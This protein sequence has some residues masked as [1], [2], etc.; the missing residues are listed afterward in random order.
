VD[1]KIDLAGG[2]TVWQMLPKPRVASM[3]TVRAACSVWLAGKL[4]KHFRRAR[5][6]TRTQRKPSKNG[7]SWLDNAGAQL[8]ACFVPEFQME[9]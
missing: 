6:Q 7:G 2:S 3:S 9:S 5:H 8:G 1:I 4:E